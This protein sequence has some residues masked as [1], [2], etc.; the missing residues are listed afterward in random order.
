MI[1]S[2]RYSR[3]SRHGPA[4]KTALIA[5]VLASCAAAAAAEGFPACDPRS[6][7]QTVTF[8]HVTDLHAR[9]Q[10]QGAAPSAYAR[11]RA[12]FEE[13]KRANP[14][15]L[16]IDG[17]DD[18]EKGSVSEILSSGA[19]T[20]EMTRAMRFDVRVLGNHDFAFGTAAALEHS[21][22]P[23]TLVLA[24]NLSYRGAGSLGFGATSYAEIQLGCLR[25]GFF[26][27]VTQPWNERDEQYAGDYPGFASR[28]DYAGLAK[29]ILNSRASKPDLT[30]L[31]SHLGREDDLA[32]AKAVS[33]IDLIL[34]G[35]THGI[36]FEPI[37]IGR[38]RVVE[39]GAF[40]EYL[41]RVD[42]AVDLSSRSSVAWSHEL[43]GVGESMP[44]D[45]ATDREARRIVKRYSGG[46]AA[47]AGCACKAAGKP[48]AAVVAARAAIQE[49]GADAA[50]IDIK[51][52]STPWNAGPV[53]AQ[54]FHDAFT[55]EREPPATPG[56]NS[57]Y[58][59]EIDGASLSTL[60]AMRD[61]SRWAYEGPDKPEPSKTYRLALPKRAALHPDEYLPKR[62]TLG[63]PRFASEVWEILE[64]YA[65]SRK[66]AGLCVDNG[67]AAPR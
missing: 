45:A 17:G 11:I 27:L 40:A 21:R 7:S 5:G 33:G 16:L 30:V 50:F 59:A 48:L 13:L 15:S 67:C 3:S 1:G 58:L 10:P 9:Y 65:L 42:A 55:I 47:A 19:A 36:T 38:T 26:G 18:H 43:S 8:V 49:L 39:S 44:F 66:K 57:F 64:R 61:A 4:I 23:R 37:L 56:F 63:P 2:A 6:S 53:G 54:E 60:R 12:R 14:Y 51:T 41:T 29:R 34:G 31:V 62:V 32:L 46:H 25:V 24:S 35:H 20:R 52:V 22:D 28:Y